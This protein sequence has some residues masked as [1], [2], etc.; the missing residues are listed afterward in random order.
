MSKDISE[1]LILRWNHEEGKFSPV[2]SD[3]EMEE[4]IFLELNMDE[5]YWKY[6]YIKGASLIAKRIA[7]RAA[8]SIA[9]A[10]YVHPNNNI[11][12]GSDLEL[13][14]ESSPYQDMPEKI[15]K[16]QRT[17]YDPSYKQKKAK[18]EN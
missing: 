5:N 10:G 3:G 14:E 11:R 7:L 13:N 9:K 8:N 18:E 16:A 12:Y 2:E 4:G 15:I 6:F 1:N 17:W